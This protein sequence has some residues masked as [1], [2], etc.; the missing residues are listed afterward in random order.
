LRARAR[1]GPPVLEPLVLE[2]VRIVLVRPRRGGNVGAAARVLKNVGLGELVLVAPRTRVGAV[3]ARM[4]AHA[5]DVL[6]ARRTAPD[7]ATAVQDCVLV[8]GT[9]GRDFAHLAPLDPRDA[10]VEMVAATARGRVALVFGPEDHGLA[11][12]D[13]GLCQRLVRIPTADA[14]PSLNLAQ[15]VAVCG[16][17]LRRAALDG[18]GVRAAPGR[19]RGRT[20]SDVDDERRPASNA[21]RE[22][23]LAHFEQALGGV[24]FLSRQNPGHILADVRA[25]FARAGLTRRDVKIWRGIARQVLWAARRR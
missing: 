21:E 10:A 4:A 18:T 19:R 24:G 14:Y 1:A 16:Y 20:T 5:R 25:L 12:A 15:A 9:A 8:V 23:L 3:G 2:R 13:L 7:L 17:E 22:E 11:N 6:A